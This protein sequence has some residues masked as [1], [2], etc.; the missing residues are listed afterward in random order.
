MVFTWIRN[1]T[2]NQRNFTQN[3]SPK[4]LKLIDLII[5]TCH[6]EMVLEFA[7][8]RFELFVVLCSIPYKILNWQ[9][10]LLF[11]IAERFAKMQVKIGLI[12]MIRNFS[13]QVSPKMILP[14]TFQPNFGL[15]TAKN[16]IWLTKKPIENNFWTWY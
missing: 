14:I 8:V 16:G 6:L 1:I 15:L 2:R 11:V 5:R 3:I 10:V 12:S 9:M 7:L 13:Y 4:K